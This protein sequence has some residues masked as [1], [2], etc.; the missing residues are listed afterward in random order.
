MKIA[1]EQAAADVRAAM[2]D[3]FHRLGASLFVV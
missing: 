1:D 3:V 2:N